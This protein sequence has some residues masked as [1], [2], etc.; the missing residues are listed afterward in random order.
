MATTH[1][2]EV[3]RRIEELPFRQLG[4]ETV[5][6]NPRSREVHVLNGTGSRIWELL[7]SQLSLAEI[8]RGLESDGEFDSEA[9]VIEQDVATFVADLVA[10][11]LVTAAGG[12][13]SGALARADGR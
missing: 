12:Q 5:V 8:V 4:D 7:E 2:D 6:V 13:A 10:K 11:G 1:T 3:Y 9:A